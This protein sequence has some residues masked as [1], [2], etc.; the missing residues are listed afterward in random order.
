MMKLLG[1]PFRMGREAQQE[2]TE[3][4]NKPDCWV[5]S[6][7]PCFDQRTTGT[8]TPALLILLSGRK[9]IH[10]FMLFRHF[11]EPSVVVI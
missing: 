10:S 1:C 7:R 2:T 3:P 8:Q 6:M 5:T 4:G 9:S 11:Q